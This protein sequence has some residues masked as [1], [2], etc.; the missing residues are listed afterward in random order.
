[1]LL[2]G[3]IRGERV[4]LRPPVEADRA[5]V[6]EIL[7]DE[8][9]PRWTRVPRPYLDEHFDRFVAMA[10]E[11]VRDG[12]DLPLLVHHLDDDRVLGAVGVHIIDE[13]DLLAEVGYWTAAEARGQGYTTEAVRLLVDWAWDHLPWE[14]LEAH[15]AAEN[16]ASLRVMEKVGFE[17]EA[18]L[19]QRVRVGG[20]RRDAVI[21]SRMR[22]GLAH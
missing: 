18:V 11:G 7:A 21:F 13:R 3:P 6:M 16:D 9:I 19:R 10:A 8:E 17:R 15:V 5:Q 2:D 20:R 12:R 1:M 22:P 4:E 14:R